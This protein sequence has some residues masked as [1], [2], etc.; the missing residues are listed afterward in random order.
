MPFFLED[1]VDEWMAEEDP[2][3]NESLV[4]MRQSRDT[5]NRLRSA[6]GFFKGKIDGVLEESSGPSIRQRTKPTSREVQELRSYRPRFNRLSADA[7]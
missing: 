1:A 4:T 3:Y 6:R 5:M 2:S 7:G